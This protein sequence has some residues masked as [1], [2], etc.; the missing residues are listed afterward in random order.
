MPAL[1]RGGIGAEVRAVD[2]QFGAGV[3]RLQPNCG[4][5]EPFLVP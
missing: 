5:V 2:T 3:E 1:L 4:R